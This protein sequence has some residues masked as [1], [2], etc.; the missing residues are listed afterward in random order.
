[1]SIT[2]E[3]PPG[4]GTGPLRG[5]RVLDFGNMIAG[6]FCARILADFGADVIKVEQPG[7]GDPVRGWRSQYRGHS[8]LWKTMNRNKRA[9]TLDLHAPD[10]QAIA[11]RLYAVADIVVENFRPGVLERWGLGYAQAQALNSGLIMVRISGYGQTGPY[12]DR[13]GFG[14]VAEALSG[15]RF[16]TGYPDRPPTRVGFALAD[17]VAGLYGAFAAMAAVRERTVSGRGQEIDVA[18]TE[19]TFSLLDDLVAAYQKL[20]QV[21]GRHGTGLPGVAP[22]SIYPTRDGQYIVIGANNDNVFRRL[23][24][25][26]HREE[27]LADPDLAHDQGRGRRQAELDAAVGAWTA[28]H[29]LGPLNDLLAAHGVPAGPVYDIA[30]VAADPQFR[31]RGAVVEID[32]P[33]V[34]PLAQP[35]VVP[36]FSRTPGRIVWTGPRQ[37]EHNAEVYGGLLGLSGADLEGLRAR[38]VI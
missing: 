27:W 11:R 31:A 16:L 18:L 38:G 25:L 33:D 3:A 34:G 10:G 8:L 20:G 6:P 26:M 4:T 17:T 7:R 21:A 2:P 36:V 1:M 28:Q 14:G 12:R 5:L 23:A 30:G 35:G 19:A 32:D 9:V 24:A 15:V 22:S 37:G 29:D 13:A